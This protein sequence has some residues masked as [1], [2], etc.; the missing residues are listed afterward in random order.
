MPNRADRPEAAESDAF[1][2]AIVASSDD[3]IIGKSLDGVVTTWN[4]GAGR[5]FGYTAD[6][7]IG[8]PI[9]K[10]FP[11]DRLDEEPKILARL[12]G[13]ERVEHFETVRVRKGGRAID[14]SVTISPVRDASGRIVG[15]SKIARDITNQKL[16]ERE[17]R[18]AREAAEAA[19]RTRDRFLGVLSHELRTPLTPVLAAVTFIESQ[20]DLPP[21]LRESVEIIRRSIQSEVRLIDDL[22][23][24]T[25]LA[26]GT[27]EIT[28]QKVD[29]HELIGTTV[30]P[31]RGEAGEKKVH[32]MTSFR[33]DRHVVRADPARLRQV[34]QNLVDNALKFTGAGGTVAVRT[35]DAPNRAVR[36]EVADTGAGI[37]PDVLPRVFEL[38]EEHDPTTGI[39]RTGLG[40]G[41]SLC[42]SIVTLHGGTVTAASGGVG[43]GAT[44]TVTLPTVTDAPVERPGPGGQASSSLKKRTG[45]ILVVE[46]HADTLAVM[47][48]LLK[49]IGF[50]VTTAGT[51]KEALDLAESHEFDLLLSDIGL[52][53]GTGAELMAQLKSTKG[54]RGIALSGL[55]FESDLARSHQAGFDAHL[56]KPINF[57]NL[58][59][60]IEQTLPRP[61]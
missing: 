35:G 43:Q 53:D 33:A 37:A 12:Q 23:D 14:V 3:A 42:R 9:T 13:G 59:R 1:L 38:F 56:T 40:M 28:P 52:P 30:Q 18:A 25:R 20:P 57:Q 22:L 7:M 6:E 10:L 50:E 39:E 31:F 21:S 46:D 34:M 4:A 26:R 49:N 36:V 15:A 24:V 47:S 16:L 2:A 45:R 51:V 5:L 32:L 55:G 44:F 61:V 8:R 41:L 29:L 48:R 58:I 54:M 27:M 11:P 17:L 60:A 19:T